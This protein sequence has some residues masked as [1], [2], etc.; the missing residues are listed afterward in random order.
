MLLLIKYT[1]VAYILLIGRKSTSTEYRMSV[2]A[3]AIIILY[4]HIAIFRSQTTLHTER[5]H[6]HHEATSKLEYVNTK[7]ANAIF[8]LS[9]LVSLLFFAFLFHSLAKNRLSVCQRMVICCFVPCMNIITIVIVNTHTTSN[10]HVHNTQAI[11]IVIIII[12]YEK[13]KIGTSKRLC[14]LL[15][16]NHQSKRRPGGNGGAVGSLHV[17]MMEQNRISK[18]WLNG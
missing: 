10:P 15:L 3:P 11:I 2:C 14:L 1:Y 17:L 4:I 7:P 6:H 12:L 8:Y 18:A 9:F 13:M 5:N 16:Y